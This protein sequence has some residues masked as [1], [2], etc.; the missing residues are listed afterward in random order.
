MISAQEM[1]SLKPS[2]L[3]FGALEVVPAT[4]RTEC[5]PGDKISQ[6]AM[7]SSRL[8]CWYFSSKKGIAVVHLLRA[9][10]L[11][12]VSTVLHGVI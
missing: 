11:V 8:D 2:Q 4:V 7:Q 1:K 6:D 9:Y 12:S 5:F 3:D 10:L